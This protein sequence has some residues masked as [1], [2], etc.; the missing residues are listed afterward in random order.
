MSMTFAP[1]PITDENLYFQGAWARMFG[2]FIQ[3]AREKAGLSVEQAAI[4][5]DMEAE[6][7][8]A[9]EAGTSLPATRQQFQ[10]MAIALEMEW[11]MMTQIILLCRQAWGIQ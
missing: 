2:R 3:S 11:A 9:V 1:L 7:W 6:R 10:F 5:A 4:L 8:L